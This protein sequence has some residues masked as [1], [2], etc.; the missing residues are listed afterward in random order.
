MKKARLAP[1]A[2]LGPYRIESRDRCRRH[3]RSVARQSRR[4]PLPG[5]VAIKTL[6]PYFGGGALRERFL[7]EALILGRLQHPGI[8][9]LLDAGV[10]ADG[11]VYLVLEYVRRC[12]HRCLV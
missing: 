5:P 4:R 9:R 10:A 6:H 3:G 2:Q 1:G 7:R 12:G 8:A 11:G